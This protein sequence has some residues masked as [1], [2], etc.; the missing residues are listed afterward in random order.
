[1]VVYKLHGKGDTERRKSQEKKSYLRQ[2]DGNKIKQNKAG[3]IQS[4]WGKREG[5]VKRKKKPVRSQ[6][7]RPRENRSER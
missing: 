2:K 4:S 3:K 6:N 1:M 5:A 7:S